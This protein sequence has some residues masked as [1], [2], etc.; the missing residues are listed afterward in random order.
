MTQGL[1]YFCLFIHHQPST[2]LKANS[3]HRYKIAFSSS[4][5]FFLQKQ[6]QEESAVAF[7]REGLMFSL[8]GPAERA[9]SPLSQSLC[10]GK[11]SALIGRARSCAQHLTP[12]AASK[13][14]PKSHVTLKRA[15][16]TDML[17]ESQM[18]FLF[19]P[20]SVCLIHPSAVLLRNDRPFHVFYS[21]TCKP[22]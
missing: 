22:R 7:L 21:A 15:G 13:D 16:R 5:G 14:F 19:T 6:Q 8:I 2:T 18:P 9:W 20:S 10:P 12:W 1:V 11:R 17:E 4:W 3:P